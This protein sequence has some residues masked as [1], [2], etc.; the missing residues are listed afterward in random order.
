MLHVPEQ[1]V[2]CSQ[3]LLLNLAEQLQETYNHG[4]DPVKIKGEKENK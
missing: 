2:V 3:L 4:T 1:G